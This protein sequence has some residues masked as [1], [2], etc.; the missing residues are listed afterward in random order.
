MLAMPLGASG[1]SA[2]GLCCLDWS[3][4]SQQ[5]LGEGTSSRAPLTLLTLFLYT[6]RASII[7]KFDPGGKVGSYLCVSARCSSNRKLKI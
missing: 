4:D 2:G 1:V 7:W 5:L 3:D 6:S